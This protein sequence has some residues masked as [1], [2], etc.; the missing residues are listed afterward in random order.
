M[1]SALFIGRFQPFHNGHLKVIRDILKENDRITIVICGPEKPNKRNPFSFK[2]REEM[3]RRVLGSEGISYETHKIT[4]VNDDD[5]W[6]EKIR[7]LG[8]FGVV[9]SRNLWTIRCLKKIGITVRKHRFY[10]RW[11]N[12][13]RIIRERILE[14]RE[15]KNL[16][17]EEVYEYVRK[18][19]GE[20]RIRKSG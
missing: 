6:N 19:N 3:L 18:I 10:K 9:Y 1:N 7:K 13:G 15:W 12:C 17:P 5:E 11:K 8:K 14:G 2:E 20:E 16:V 4:D